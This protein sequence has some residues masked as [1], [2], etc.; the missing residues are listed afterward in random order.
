MAAPAPAIPSRPPVASSRQS[1]K[2]AL[3]IALFVAA[4]FVLL[5]SE[6]PLL[7]SGT[8]YDSYRTQLIHD[9][10]LLF[11]HAL[12][13]VTALLVGPLQFSSRLRTRNLKLHRTLGRVYVYSVFIA[14][15]MGVRIAWGRPLMVATCVQAGAWVVCTLAALLTAR[16]RQIVQHRQWMVRSYAVT[17]TFISLRVLNPWPRYWNMSNQTFVLMIILVTFASVLLADVGLNWRE[18]TTRRA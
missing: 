9:W 3:W 17:F 15:T 5:T 1:G 10:L 6:L 7:R 8:M 12:C 11:P 16:N 2:L 4:F 18:L 14:A 13:G